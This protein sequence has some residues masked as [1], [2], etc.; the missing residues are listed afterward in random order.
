M[1]AA[2]APP[3]SYPT[4]GLSEYDIH[5]A[6]TSAKVEGNSRESA[7]AARRLAKISELPITK[8]GPS[9]AVAQAI[10]K[11]HN[12]IFKTDA[13]LSEEDTFEHWNQT[14]YFLGP[15]GQS[16]YFQ[17]AKPKKRGSRNSK[18]N[19]DRVGLG[20]RLLKYKCLLECVSCLPLHR[21]LSDQGSID[22]SGA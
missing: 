2:K 17:G 6:L 5:Q 8:R 19:I 7:L 11:P 21:F 15:R 18:F 13:L 1:L 12:V 3:V 4:G 10:L 16:T 22:A 20:H 14:Q 9:M